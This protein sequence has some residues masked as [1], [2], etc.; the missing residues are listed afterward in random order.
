MRYLV[1]IFTALA[2]PAFAQQA[3]KKDQYDPEVPKPT[4]SEVRYGDHER[5]VI[6]F[7]QAES[8]S[9]TPVAFV[10]HGGGWMGGSKERLQRFADAPRLLKAGISVASINYRYVRQAVEE[11]VEPPVKA[12]LHD[13]AR[14]LQFIR[15]KAKEWNIDKERIGAAGG[16]AG[17]CSSLWL[18]FHDDLADPDSDDP[19]ARESS[20][21]MCAAVIGAQ[22]SLDPKQMKDWT[23][24]SK[25][26]AHA[27]GLKN[28]A[29]FLEKREEILPWIKE[30]SPYAL[31]TSDDPDVYL[32]Y[33][34]P[35]AIGK[36]QKDP[37][38]SANFGVKLQKHC[39][40]NGTSCDFVYEGKEDVTY[41]NTTD[42]L[43]AKLS[44]G[45]D[46]LGKNLGQWKLQ[47]EGAWE[48]KDGVLQT[49]EKPG[50]Y[51][52]SKNAY[53]NFQISLEYKT[54]EK[55]NSGLF[56]RTDPKNAVQGGFE[57]Q[58]AS[59]GNYDGKHVVGSLYDAK[60]PSEAAGKPDGE[61]NTMILTCAGPHI[62]VVLNGKNILFANIDDWDT[63]N[64]NPDGSK[65][66]FKTALKDLPRSG[67]FGLQYH[68]HPV[69][70][71]NIVLKEL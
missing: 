56:F 45:K 24:N 26:G 40:K 1:W 17:A 38:H 2:V 41:A 6:D 19:V 61:W 53:E 18:A 60:P 28:F 33:R 43:I 35:P 57:I 36:E 29:E 50:G 63:A 8:D 9:P 58:I 27:F 71:R 62:S 68:G 34:T 49:S 3:K 55:C 39:E 32:W 31:V 64:Q 70:F 14:A 4:F 52:W 12:P 20:R 11:G 30:Y 44:K 48:L 47:K 67:H 59:D 42:F 13:A 54:S 69:W 21:L 7:W 25:Y 16:S 5:H 10:I 22:T 37:T 51:I 65:N 46:L 66:K 23:P 15:S